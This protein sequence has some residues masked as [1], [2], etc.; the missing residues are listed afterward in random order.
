MGSSYQRQQ[1]DL[2]HLDMW[3]KGQALFPGLRVVLGLGSSA[4]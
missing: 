4:V 2:G 3:Q 1:D